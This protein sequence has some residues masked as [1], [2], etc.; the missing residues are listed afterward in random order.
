MSNNSQNAK[1]NVV[2][3]RTDDLDLLNRLMLERMSI[4]KAIALRNVDNT[5]NPYPA[6]Q[7]R[8]VASGAAG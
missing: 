5:T 4:I 3:Y 6:A 8:H 1:I 2:K 7:K